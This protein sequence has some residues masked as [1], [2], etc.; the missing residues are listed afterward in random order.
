MVKH[1]ENIGERERGNLKKVVQD[2]SDKAAKA[3]ANLS[4]GHSSRHKV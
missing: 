4:E 1:G 2:M 3:K